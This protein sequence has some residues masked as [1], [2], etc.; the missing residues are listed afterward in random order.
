MSMFGFRR[1]RLVTS[2]ETR[3]K[4]PRSLLKIIK[5]LAL[6]TTKVARGRS[7]NNHRIRRNLEEISLHLRRDIGLPPHGSTFFVARD[8]LRCSEPYNSDLSFGKK[9]VSNPTQYSEP[10]F[11]PLQSSVVVLLADIRGFTTISEAMAPEDVM[12]LLQ[13]FYRRIEMIAFRHCGS[14]A[15]STGDML[16]ITFGLP[17]AGPSDATNALTCAR[18]MLDKQ[19]WWNLERTA[20]G[21][22]PIA[23]GIGVHYGAVVS[24]IMGGERST[25]FSVIGDTVNVANRLESLTRSLETDLVISAALIKKVSQE[26][27]PSQS[28]AKIDDLVSIGAQFLE[29]RSETIDAYFLPKDREL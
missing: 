8:T 18:D 25:A 14:V 7:P 23:I 22:P 6:E 10:I 15:V 4:C 21:D 12:D 3:G 17:I 24:G 11:L 5:R 1:R 28:A 2:Q 9:L 16:L 27:N 20:I 13:E 26:A 19:R 29:G